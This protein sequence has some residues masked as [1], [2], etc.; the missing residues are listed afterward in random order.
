MLWNLWSEVHFRYF[1]NFDFLLIIQWI[2]LLWKNCYY[3]VTSK[4][5]YK[6]HK[7]VWKISPVWTFSD[8]LQNGTLCAIWYN[9]C[10]FIK[11][12]TLAWVFLTFFKIVQMVPNRAKYHTLCQKHRA[13]DIAWELRRNTIWDFCVFLYFFL[14][15]IFYLFFLLSHF[16]GRYLP[17]KT[18]TE[19]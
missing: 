15:F 1:F 13:D 9:L 2:L 4:F 3:W 18:W 11:S 5:W 16:H 12:N 19:A 17:K 10:N 7:E 8:F 14:S 6:K